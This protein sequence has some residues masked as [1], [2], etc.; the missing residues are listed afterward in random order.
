MLDCCQPHNSFHPG[1]LRVIVSSGSRCTGCRCRYTRQATYG[2]DGSL[3]HVAAAAQWA[4]ASSAPGGE[5]V[6]APEPRT[7]LEE[8]AEV[9]NAR[10]MPELARSLGA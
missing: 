9:C 3:L 7:K 4:S 2:A 6:T 8:A 1:C 10:V 5:C